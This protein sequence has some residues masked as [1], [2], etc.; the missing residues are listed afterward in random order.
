MYAL[1][2]LCLLLHCIVHCP[3]ALYMASGKCPALGKQFGHV[4]NSL[5]KTKSSVRFQVNQ[6]GTHFTGLVNISSPM[7]AGDETLLSDR[8]VKKRW[9]PW[10]LDIRNKQLLI[11]IFFSHRRSFF[12]LQVVLTSTSLLI[13]IAR[14]A[15]TRFT[16]VFFYYMQLL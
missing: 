16:G 15:H 11:G 10:M 12:C 14:A 7:N 2:C 13:L 8:M 6:Q 5:D 4:R 1:S 9:V 3:A